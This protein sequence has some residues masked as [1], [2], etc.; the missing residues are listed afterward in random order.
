MTNWKGR[1]QDQ[2]QL[3]DWFVFPYWRWYMVEF[4]PCIQNIGPPKNARPEI[5][6]LKICQDISRKNEIGQVAAWFFDKGG[7]Y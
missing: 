6:V 5:S 7:L 3:K 1:W 4:I 2:N